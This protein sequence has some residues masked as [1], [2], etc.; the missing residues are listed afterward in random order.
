MVYRTQ[1]GGEASPSANRQSAL[2][3]KGGMREEF[4][5]PLE[6]ASFGQQGGGFS[7]QPGP[8]QP[9][10]IY[11]QVLCRQDRCAIRSNG[12]MLQCMA[13]LMQ[14]TGWQP[15]GRGEE[16]AFWLDGGEEQYWPCS[17]RPVLVRHSCKDS[18]R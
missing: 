15:A 5:L 11:S 14:I 13:V 2:L 6:G 8:A 3:G 9:A 16:M 12:Q 10:G 17:S 4:A 18:S 7:Q 1:Q